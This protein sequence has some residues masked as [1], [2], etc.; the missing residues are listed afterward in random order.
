MAAK[1][2]DIKNKEDWDFFEF[3]DVCVIASN[4]VYGRVAIAKEARTIGNRRDIY[5]NALLIA[6][7]GDI[8]IG[9]DDHKAYAI[10]NLKKVEV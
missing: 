3:V 5:H 2:K 10:G 4:K 1:I 6:D 8:V 9:P 7:D